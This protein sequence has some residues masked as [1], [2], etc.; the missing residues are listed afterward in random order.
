M[1]ASVGKVEDSN[2]IV[3]ALLHD[4]VEDT[5]TS[6][7]EIRER[8][9]Q[10]V[11]DIVAEVTDDKSLR[12]QDRKRLQIEHAPQLSPGAKLIKIADKISNVSEIAHD[13]PKKW[14][15]SR[16]RKYFDWAEQ[17]VNAMGSIDPELRLVF[18]KTLSDARA[19]LESTE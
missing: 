15:L 5:E 10:L 6:R 14:S 16:R 4:I 11:D 13:P 18:D 19:L 3:A 7:E 17:V 8:F 1:L 9:G 2:V 12:K